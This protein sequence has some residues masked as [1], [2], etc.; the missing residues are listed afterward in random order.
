MTIPRGWWINGYVHS[1]RTAGANA[2][3]HVRREGNRDRRS[4]TRAALTHVVHS[5]IVPVI[6]WAGQKDRFKGRAV[7]RIARIINHPS[8]TRGVSS[9]SMD[10]GFGFGG[11]QFCGWVAGLPWNQGGG[12]HSST[13]RPAAAATWRIRR[14]GRRTRRT[15]RAARL[16]WRR[17]RRAV[18][19]TLRQ[20]ELFTCCGPH[21]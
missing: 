6:A 15:R 19:V 13:A 7:T 8:H 3:G 14:W 2:A 20:V 17:G 4:L 21:G 1:S 9:V 10:T 12:P 5:A 11:S 16:W 18:P